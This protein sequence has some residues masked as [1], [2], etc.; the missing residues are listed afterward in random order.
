MWLAREV[1]EELAE[2]I[3]AENIPGVY[4][5]PESKRVYPYKNVAAQL[6][7]FTDI[8]ERGLSGIEFALD[9]ELR[10]KS[11]RALVQKDAFGTKLASVNYEVEEPQPGKDVVLTIDCVYQSVVEEELRRS[12]REFGADGGIVIVLNP[13]NGEILALSNE[14]SFDNNHARSSDANLWRNRAIT[15]VFEPGSTFKV[16]LMSAILQERIRTLKNTVFCENG[17]YNI[18]DQTVRDHKGYGT[19]GVGE[20]LVYSSNV[21]MA[22]LSKLIEPNLFYKYARDFGFGNLTNIELGGEIQGEL[23]HPVEWSEFTSIAMGMGYEV[24]VTPMQLAMAYAAIANGGKLLKPQIVSRVDENVKNSHAV[25]PDVIR[26]VLT[27]ASARIMR[28]LLYQVVEKGTGTKARI[29]GIDICGKTGTA[30]KYASD[31]RSYSQNEFIASFVGFYPTQRPEILICTMIDNPR[32]TYWGG[33]VA[34]PTFKRIVQRLSGL[35]DRFLRPKQEVKVAAANTNK[36][37]ELLTRL[38]DFT[39]RRWDQ[40]Q[41]LLEELGVKSN[42]LN[43]GLVV[44]QQNPPP[45]TPIDPSMKVDFTLFDISDDTTYQLTPKVIGLSMRE[46]VN[47][48][49]LANLKIEIHGNG[50][51]VK[52]N[53]KPGERVRPGEKCRVECRSS[54]KPE[55]FQAW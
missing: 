28:D 50:R 32:T 6:L 4:V 37:L 3:I 49:A 2:K 39:N 23:K 46:A 5:I 34:A 26:Q 17:R 51:V 1:D 40:S 48:L 55:L 9:R 13:K 53:P 30:H 24:A 35:D 27:P 29:E 43:Q 54:V 41:E 14:P 12:I 19:L 45:G 44:G 18:L 7:G 16:V 8:D 36:S 22:K 15:D 25:K 38:P 10:G 11:G 21:G 31:T 42:A 47:R 52:Q 33:E 20:V